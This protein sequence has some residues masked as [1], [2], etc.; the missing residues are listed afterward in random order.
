[1]SL[2]PALESDA[3]TIVLLGNYS[4]EDDFD[5]FLNQPL[6]INR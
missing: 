1:M 3:E 4:I 6:R 5:E 2:Q